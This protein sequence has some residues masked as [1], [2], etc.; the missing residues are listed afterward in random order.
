MPVVPVVVQAPGVDSTFETYALLDSGSTSSFCSS[1]LMD[2]LQ[3]VGR[4]EILSLTTLERASSITKADIVSL[5]V[6]DLGKNSMIEIPRVYVRE[7]LPVN[8][9]NVAT[10]VDLQAWPH[11]SQLM[12]HY[13]QDDVITI[14][15]LIGQ[16]VPEALMPREVISES[17]DSPY[18]VRTLL[19]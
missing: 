19:G 9:D 16:D 17:S 7:R 13:P 6:S 3:L 15:L 1:R 18:A 14:D 12:L 4:S 2:R 5:Q 8:A 11:L 10:L